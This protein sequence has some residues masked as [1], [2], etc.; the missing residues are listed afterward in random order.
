MDIVCFGSA[1]AIARSWM[2]VY[3]RR[4][5]HTRNPMPHKRRL[6]GTF[7]L[8]MWAVSQQESMPPQP[9]PRLQCCP[10]L[11]TRL[12]LRMRALPAQP[13]R[14]PHQRTTSRCVFSRCHAPTRTNRQQTPREALYGCHSRRASTSQTRDW[15]S[16]SQRYQHGL[17]RAIARNHTRTRKHIIHRDHTQPK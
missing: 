4:L 10:R 12:L 13:P 15:R 5:Y 8:F 7:S 1:F 6:P 14:N 16:L 2:S 3:T 11:P 17:F 9:I